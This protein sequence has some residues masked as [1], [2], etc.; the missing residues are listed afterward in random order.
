MDDGIVEKEY[1]SLINN[2]IKEEETSNDSNEIL[3]EGSQEK[4]TFTFRQILFLI[5]IG[6]FSF[7]T[8]FIISF[9]YNEVAKF[10]LNQIDKSRSFFIDFDDLDFSLFDKFNLKKTCSINR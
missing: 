2:P 8:F 1:Q 4:V 7:S 3:Q 5:L 9:P 6:F 10:Y